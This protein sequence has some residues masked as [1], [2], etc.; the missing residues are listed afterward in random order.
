MN[1]REL[2]DMTVAKV[3]SPSQAD[4]SIDISD[5]FVTELINEGLHHIERQA[6]WEFAE[7]AAIITA[8]SGI[9]TTP[10]PDDCHT[11]L[12]AI[13]TRTGID[14]EFTDVRQEMGHYKFDNYIL[15]GFRPHVQGEITHYGLWTNQYI[16]GPIPRRD[17]QINLRY[18]RHFPRLEEDEDEPIIPETYHDIL[19]NY[20]ASRLILAL[21]AEG[22]RYLPWSMAEPYEQM[23]QQG[24]QEML[25]SPLVVI[26]DQIPLQEYEEFI[27]T[28]RP[29]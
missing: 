20:A 26:Q 11:T 29:F 17:T 27:W 7:T 5:A 12:K 19:T 4:A 28:E 1:L 6:L 23:W 13:N 15:P 24:L 2:V 16:W 21:P 3:R 18:Y 9:P 10:V 14:L 22:N 25:N 8:I